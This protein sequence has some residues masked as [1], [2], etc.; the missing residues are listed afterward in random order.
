LAQAILAQVSSRNIIA[1][2]Y[3]YELTCLTSAVM[4]LLVLTAWMLLVNAPMAL[5]LSPGSSEPDSFYHKIVNAQHRGELVELCNQLGLTGN[6]AEIG[7]WH[8]GFSRHNLETWKGKKYYMIDSWGFRPDDKDASGNVSEDKNI[9][10]DAENEHN[11]AIAMDAVAKW[12]P[13]KGD[14]A[15][16]K[17]NNSEDAV[18]DFADEFFDFI[19]VDAGHAYRNVIHDLRMW[20]PK[21]KKGGMIAGDDFA[22]MHDSFPAKQF[23]QAFH[24]GVKSAVAQFAKEIG[25][26]FFLTFA[27]RNHATTEKHPDDKTEWEEDGDLGAIE[28]HPEMPPK[29][30]RVRRHDMYPAW[31]LFK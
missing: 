28:K 25:S 6:A 8:G 23:A 19:Y 7:V 4:C 1:E 11:F 18:K 15:I 31:Y 26:P 16:V 5:K 12:L 27:D 17:R 2:N 10:D 20:W 21:L 24:W 3:N 30:F 14:R 9:K 13:P 22:D 29:E